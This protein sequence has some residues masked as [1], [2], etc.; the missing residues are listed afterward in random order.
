MSELKSVVGDQV[1]AMARGAAA[2]YLR[3][4]KK[5]VTNRK[6]VV[7]VFAYALRAA[8][9][10]LSPDERAAWMKLALSEVQGT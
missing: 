9:D 1:A 8:L 6:A 3:I 4:A 10:E 7:V 5:N 2:D